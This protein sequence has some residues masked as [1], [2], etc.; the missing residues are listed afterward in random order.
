[1]L[2]R[3]AALLCSARDVRPSDVAADAPA[4][5]ELIERAAHMLHAQAGGLAEPV[6]V[7]PARLPGHQVEQSLRFL[8]VTK[9]G[10]LQQL[11]Q[12]L[13]AGHFHSI[14]LELGERPEVLGEPVDHDLG[15]VHVGG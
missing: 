6:R 12:L 2:N 14:L 15:Y 4:Q 5:L 10:H 11:P 3:N 8:A 1:M 9:L 13:R 7:P